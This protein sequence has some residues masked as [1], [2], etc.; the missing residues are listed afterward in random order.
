M[1]RLI[2]LPPA[3]LI[4]VALFGCGEQAKQP[5]A[6]QPEPE[7]PV[8]RS[9]RRP[10]ETAIEGPAR[11]QPAMIRTKEE[12]RAALKAKNPD[13]DGEPEVGSD[14]QIITAVMINDPAIED[15]SPLAGLPLLQLDLTGCHVTDIRPLEGMPLGILYLG[16]TGVRDV[17]VLQGMPLTQLYLNETRVEDLRALKGAERLQQLNLIGSRVSDL[18]P[19]REMPL[20]ETLWL[21]RCPLRDISPLSDVPSLVSLTI[22]ETKVSDLSPLEGKRRLKRLHIARTDVTD[23]SVLQSLRLERLIFTPGRIKKG[24]EFA[25]EMPGLWQIDV[26]F[27]DQYDRP[28]S[29]DEFWPLYD[30]GKFE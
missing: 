25:R 18:S 20:L 27:D 23:L 1:K 30:A 28:M 5:P 9:A 6:R 24:L 8:E 7:T 3:A 4:A 29:P 19:L 17:S 15:I 26:R 12:L 13:F 11:Q 21:T 14:G 10:A 22:A 2:S 16:E